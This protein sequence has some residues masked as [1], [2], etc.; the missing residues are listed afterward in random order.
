MTTAVSNHSD[1]AA[2]KSLNPLPINFI[3]ISTMKKAEK[4]IFKMSNLYSK[5]LFYGY[6]LNAR[7]QT[8]ASMIII[9]SPVNE[10]EF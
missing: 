5:L 7:T 8:F 1:F 6:L 3:I 10:F 4:L 9:E 2:K